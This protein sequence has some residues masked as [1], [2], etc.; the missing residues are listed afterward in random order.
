MLS[1]CA[2]AIVASPGTD[3]AARYSYGS[4]DRLR[5]LAAHPPG[6]AGTVNR[7]SDWIEK[8]SLSHGRG[9]RRDMLP[10]VAVFA[11]LCSDIRRSLY[12]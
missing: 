12:F 5:G 6:M 11:L 2:D 3:L 7:V 1:G 9:H 8:G 4:L 10:P